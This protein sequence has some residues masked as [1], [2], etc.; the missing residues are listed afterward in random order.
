MKTQQI[1]I[2]D[3]LDLIYLGKRVRIPVDSPAQAKNLRGMLHTYNSRIKTGLSSIGEDTSLVL[4]IVTETTEDGAICLIAQQQKET[5]KALY[6][7][8]LD[9]E[10]EESDGQKRQ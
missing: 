1:G 5:V 2:N 3:I 10:A 7:I 6:K 9:E 4:S 8:I